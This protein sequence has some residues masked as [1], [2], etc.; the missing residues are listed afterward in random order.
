MPH[1]LA[2][3]SDAGVDGDAVV[4]I[5]PPTERENARRGYDMVGSGRL[6]ALSSGRPDQQ[7]G[8]AEA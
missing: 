4:V 1:C 6:S 5:V 8:C 7:V 2:A 3:A